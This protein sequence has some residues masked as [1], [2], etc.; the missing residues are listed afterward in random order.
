MCIRDSYSIDEKYQIMK[1]IFEDLFM[2][3]RK[4]QVYL[5]G[6]ILKTSMCHS[7]REAEE[8]ADASDV[9]GK[10]AELLENHVPKEL[11]GV[12]FLSGGLSRETATSF[13]DKISESQSDEMRNKTTFSF[14][15]AIQTEPMDIWSG[16]DKKLD[17]ARKRYLEILKEN[18]LAERGDY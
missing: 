13:F 1:S 9:G 12:V 3:L 4:C 16:D 8:W 5:P 15:R 11:G 17:A 2:V 10:T 14:S 7:G 6:V 18:S